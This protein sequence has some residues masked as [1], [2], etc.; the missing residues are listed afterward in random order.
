ML[1]KQLC[2]R[3]RANIKNEQK[4]S[5]YILCYSVQYSEASREAEYPHRAHNQNLCAGE[6]LKTTS[7]VL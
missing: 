6:L 4:T 5:D 7:D 3:D 1:C 2:S